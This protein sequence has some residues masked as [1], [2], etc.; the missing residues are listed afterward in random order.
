[1]GGR[2]EGSLQQ[3]G[4]ECHTP[5]A[6]LQAEVQNPETALGLGMP[7]SSCSDG[8]EEGDLVPT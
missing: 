6:C 8:T 4:K 3:E 1:M 5:Q 7:T 2:W